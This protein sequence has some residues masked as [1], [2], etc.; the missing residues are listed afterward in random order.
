VSMS[1]G[2]PPGNATRDDEAIP[3]I[4][5]GRKALRTFQISRM[6]KTAHSPTP[7]TFVP[8]DYSY[9]LKSLYGNHTWDGG[10]AIATCRRGEYGNAKGSAQP[11]ESPPG[12]DCRCGLYGTLTIDQLI[13]EYGNAIRSNGCI[14]VFTAEGDTVIGSAGLRTA[15]ARI[16]GYWVSTENGGYHNAEQAFKEQCPEAKKC[17]TI[18]ELLSEFGFEPFK[19]TRLAKTAE[20]ALTQ[21]HARYSIVRPSV[22]SAAIPAPASWYPTPVSPSSVWSRLAPLLTAATPGGIAAIQALAGGGGGGGSTT[23]TPAGNFGVSQCHGC[24]K[25]FALPAPNQVYLCAACISNNVAAKPQAK[26]WKSGDDR[27]KK[28]DGST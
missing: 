9:Q 20:E 26:P 12:E 17:D 5:I 19:S 2:P 16:V 24:G 7:Y 14:A 18:A 4:E 8:N 10:K 25:S 11:C 23:T 15:A 1:G 28:K 27:A 13:K 3:D 21:D 22:R 6:T